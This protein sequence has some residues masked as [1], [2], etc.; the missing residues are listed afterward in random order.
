MDPIK[1]I[2]RGRERTIFPAVKLWRMRMRR[3]NALR[4]SL[5]EF[6]IAAKGGD[7]EQAVAWFNSPLD[8]LNGKRP[9]DLFNPTSIRVLD[10]FVRK[11][12]A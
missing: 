11:T 7:A 9:K 1:R 6:V 8:A 4:A 10:T 3:Y 5:I 12:F 2:H